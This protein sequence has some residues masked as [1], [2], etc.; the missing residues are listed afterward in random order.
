M[1]GG[2]LVDFVPTI[3]PCGSTFEIEFVNAV[4][5]AVFAIV[6]NPGT[7][8]PTSY[9]GASQV[10]TATFSTSTDGQFIGFTNSLFD[11]ILIEPDITQNHAANI[12]NLHFNYSAAPAC[13]CCPKSVVFADVPGRPACTAACRI[14]RTVYRRD[15]PPA[16][17]ALRAQRSDGGHEK[18]A[19]VDLSQLVYIIQPF[20]HTGRQA[21]VASLARACE[22][23]SDT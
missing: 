16:R 13:E 9:L 4:S 22:N 2:R 3:C 14:V 10:E 23:L 6:T 18:L 5:D 11:R 7:S 1:S 15:P 8:I 21:I 12:D 17:S 19:M 20:I